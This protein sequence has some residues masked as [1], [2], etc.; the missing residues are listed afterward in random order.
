M[1]RLPTWQ[2]AIRRLGMPVTSYVIQ[3]VLPA[4]AFGLI[5]GAV[6]FFFSSSLFTGASGLLLALIFPLLSGGLAVVW[7]LIQTQRTAIAIEREM[8]MFITRMGILSLGDAGAQ[9]MFDILKQMGDYGALADEVQAIETL[10]ERWHTNLPE[11][12]RIVGR[13]SPSPIWG[14]FL[15]RMAFSVE[16][17]QPLEEFMRSEQDTFQEEFN[18]LYDTRLE[19]VD[20]L[21]EIYISITTTGMFL[22]VVAGIHLVLFM[23]GSL[24]DDPWTVLVRIRWILLAALI[25][26]L[27]QLFGL[28]FF[29]VLI[30]DDDLFARNDVATP[31]II[32][33]RRTWALAAIIGLGIIFTIFTAGFVVD[34][35]FI[36][37]N[38]DRYGLLSIAV[39]VTPFAFPA[40][41]VSRE[42]KSVRRRD[43]SYPGFIRALGGTAQARAAEPSATVRALKDIDFGALNTSIDMLEK[44]LSM[45]INSDNSWTW[46]AADTNS[47]MVSRFIRIYLEGAQTSGEPA[48]VAELVS[49][50]TTN[51]LSLR[52]RRALSSGTMQ[53]VAFGV[54]I[55]MITSLNITISIVQGLGSSI[56]GVAQGLVGTD[57]AA[58]PA[59]A[60]GFGLPV[61]DDS[62]VVEQN[63]FLF[64]VLVSILV[65]FMIMVLGFISARI[66]GGGI[67]LSVGQMITMLWVAGLTSLLTAVL[68][69]ASIGLFIS[70]AAN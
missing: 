17:G 21:R 32:R 25:Y 41:L 10:V 29:I 2:I 19:A 30:P 24:D 31:Y 43:E 16:A 40:Y 56:S 47:M 28:I 55:A 61:L 52:R 48:G 7:P 39:I 6:I 66:R 42:E 26:S 4:T 57:A 53:G 14:D 5:L 67:A 50:N 38:W 70:N 68:L 51:L 69:D 18:T 1:E 54:L 9:S 12:A 64:K 37:D 27:L 62:T 36:A 33:M 11:A 15:D 22:L 59:M 58:I 60:G 49:K 8:H 20:T 63:I 13:Q 45:R 34:Y 23:T 44:R 65:I 3:V 46:F 35:T